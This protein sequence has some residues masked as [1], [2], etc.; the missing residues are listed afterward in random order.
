MNTIGS[1][2][3]N[4]R[5]DKDIKQSDLANQIGITK[6]MLSKYENDINI[7]KADI[8]S[9]IVDVLDTTTDYLL[10]RTNN[11]APLSKNNQIKFLDD[12]HFKIYNIA[13]E[14]NL[15]NKIRLLERANT[16]L[17]LQ[18]EQNKN[19]INPLKKDQ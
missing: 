10:C 17:D 2:I 18:K 5:A 6:S 14:L 3:L 19:Q 15:A 1:R 13:D 9:K 4:L 7:P 12:Y 11:S 8:L 16:L